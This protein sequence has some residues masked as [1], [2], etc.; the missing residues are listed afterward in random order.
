MYLVGG[1]VRDYVIRLQYGRNYLPAS[2]DIDI[3]VV[4]ESFESMREDITHTYA[5]RIV[6]ED[7][8]KGVIRTRINTLTLPFKGIGDSIIRSVSR[9][10]DS[11]WV[12]FKLA[13]TGVH[14]N[15]QS[16]DDISQDLNTREILDDNGGATDI[17]NCVV[18][19]TGNAADRIVE[20]YLRVLR[21]Y[22]FAALLSNGPRPW[23][24]ADES[25]YAIRDNAEMVAAGLRVHVSKDR[26]VQEIGSIFKGLPTLKAIGIINS[27]PRPIQRVIFDDKKSIWL[28]PTTEQTPKHNTDRTLTPEEIDENSGSTSQQQGPS[29]SILQ[30]G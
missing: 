14:G 10:G 12:D 26:I 16:V 20:D 17:K 7:I 11:I 21:A 18:R 22:R 23:V 6:H 19:F 24:I 5:A 30:A 29:V 1:S 27:M 8:A 25:L 9:D 28:T 13:S 15:Y 3:A 2:K 4:A